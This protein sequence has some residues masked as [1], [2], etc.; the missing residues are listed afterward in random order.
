[1]AIAGQGQQPLKSQY[2]LVG[3]DIGQRSAQALRGGQPAF[4]VD[5]AEGVWMNFEHR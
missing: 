1:M 5:M 2:R 3:L 4:T